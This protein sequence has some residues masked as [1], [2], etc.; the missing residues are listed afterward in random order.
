[1]NLGTL[2]H[3]LT[4]LS[5]SEERYRAGRSFTQWDHLKKVSL[6][7]REVYII[8]P[9]THFGSDTPGTN[10]VTSYEYGA[11]A[12]LPKLSIKRNSRFN[13]VPEHIHSH[14][15]INYVYS[16][17]CPQII[18]GTPILLEKNQVLLIDTNCPHSIDSLGEEDIMISLLVQK[19]Y[20]REHIFSQF[21]QDSVLSRFF[22][23]AINE[24][25]NHDHFLLFHSE[26]NRRIPLFFR[27]LFC[28]CYDPS[29]NSADII[30]HLFCTIMAELINVYENDLTR[31]PSSL[32][33]VPII[34]MIRYIENNF[35]TCTQESV[36]R[37]FHISP[38]YVSSL[39]KKYT[40]MTYIQMTQEQKLKYAANLLTNTDCSVTEA[41]NRAGYENVSFFYK[42]FQKKYHCSPGEYRSDLTQ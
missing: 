42:K 27:E 14:I 5:P 11:A 37:F 16:G 19:D 29:I 31:R 22:I 21:S 17:K 18:D 24:R 28:E 1:M 41:A 4:K 40:G 8:Q 6:H 33:T 36:A 26:D 2:H 3:Y 7:G 15:E 23:N 13:P 12:S 34:P 32:G 20:L 9:D 25:T 38:N 39:L 35:L 10:L 30:L